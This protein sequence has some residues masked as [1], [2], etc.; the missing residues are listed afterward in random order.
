MAR[1]PIGGFVSQELI[2]RRLY[3]AICDNCHS[4]NPIAVPRLS[5]QLHQIN[6][7]EQRSF[8]DSEGYG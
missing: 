1:L 4:R 7:R 6:I 8:Q 3:V 2:T 5:Q